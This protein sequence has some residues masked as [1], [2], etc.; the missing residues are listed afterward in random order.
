MNK[1]LLITFCYLPFVSCQSF[2]NVKNTKNK[3]LNKEFTIL[4]EPKLKTDK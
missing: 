3:S 2:Q 4:I 1:F